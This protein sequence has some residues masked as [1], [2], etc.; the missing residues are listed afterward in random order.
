M[1]SVIYLTLTV[2]GKIFIKIFALTKRGSAI[3]IKEN[4]SAA[5]NAYFP[6]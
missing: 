5:S 1:K 4:K 3:I 2:Q 6:S